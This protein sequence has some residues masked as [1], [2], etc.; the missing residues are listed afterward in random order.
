LPVD[1]PR[2]AADA[3]TL[4]LRAAPCPSDGTSVARGLQDVAAT[5]PQR[6]TVAHVPAAGPS[7][8]DDVEGLPTYQQ[9]LDEALEE[10]F[11]ASDPISPTAAMSA[12]E[13]VATPR[14]TTDWT[15]DPLGAPAPSPPSVPPPSPPTARPGPYPFPTTETMRRRAA[16]RRAEQTRLT[17]DAD[18]KPVVPPVHRDRKRT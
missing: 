1:L 6:F 12:D 4:T 11:P 15:L 16:A 3:Q 8:G 14:D 2:Q 18:G 9:L 7:A 13:P 17:P 5:T 10:T